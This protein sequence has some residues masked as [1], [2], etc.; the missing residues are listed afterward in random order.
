MAQGGIGPYRGPGGDGPLYVCLAC[1]GSAH[2]AA[3]T[4]ARCGVERSLASEPG[5]VEA[6]RAVAEQQLDRRLDR[7]Y[8]AVWITAIVVG[9]PLSWLVSLVGDAELWL[10]LTL[11]AIVGMGLGL[12]A[13]VRRYLPGSS[14]A[15]FAER[16][17][18][19]KL[20]LEMDADATPSL[21]AGG[22]PPRPML[23]GTV[24]EAALVFVDPARADVRALL[25]AL[26]IPIE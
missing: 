13:L 20:E 25:A 22:E 8:A 14:L 17:R 2:R 26:Q 15:V 7:E 16:K 12:T 6:L 23:P 4:C 5:V 19:L 18:R 21:A 11:G 9:L 1:L 3:G 24:P 10:Q